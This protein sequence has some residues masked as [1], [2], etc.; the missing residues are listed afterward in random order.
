M[1]YLI[2]KSAKF[3]LVLTVTYLQIYIYIYI[4]IYMD[5]QK[6]KNY[7]TKEER[8]NVIRRSKTHYM[9]S[10]IWYCEVCDH[11]YFL[12]SWKNSAS[13]NGLTQLELPKSTP[14]IGSF[15]TKR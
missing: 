3:G 1:I 11:E 7:K 2:Y 12:F 5:N 4:Y 14:R 8:K 10:K 9:L 15:R 13:Q 6:V